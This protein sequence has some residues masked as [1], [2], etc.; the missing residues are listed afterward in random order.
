MKKLLYL[1]ATALFFAACTS[2]S[3]TINGTI[4]GIADGVKVYLNRA[5][6]N[7]LVT[8]DSTT[9][10]Q[11]KFT[12]Q[13]SQK[14]PAERY[15]TIQAEEMGRPMI[16]D[17]FLENG[18]IDIEIGEESVSVTGTPNNDIMQEIRDVETEISNQASVIVD[19]LSSNELS[20]TEYAEKVA[21]LEAL[22]KQATGFMVDAIKKNIANPIGIMLFKQNY[23]YMTFDELVEVTNQIP[24]TYTN[25][26]TIQHIIDS[27]EKMKGTA[28]GQKF[29]DF[30]MDTPE[31]TEVRLSDYV[32]KGKLVLIDFWASWCGPCRNSNPTL[33]ALYNDYKDKGFEIVGVSLDK[34]KEDWIEAIKEDGITWPQ[35][36]DLMRNPGEIA[37]IYAIN[38]IPHTILVDGEG[39]II[40]RGLHG[41][42]IR[43]KVAEILK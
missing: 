6:D 16:L 8:I 30:T 31:G 9:I 42:Q 13:G 38:S 2:D 4:E 32:G 22:D 20:E 34:S 18:N 11:G 26:E 36:S 25:D 27:V 35:M 21:Q 17:I 33:V 41:D 29:T 28:E 39:T 24:A 19:A 10:Q 37:Q 14:E 1:A 15:I 3:Y 23:Y 5:E 7:N 12:F 40:A 43:E